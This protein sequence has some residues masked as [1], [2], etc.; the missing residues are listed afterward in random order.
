MILTL[1]HKRTWHNRTPR[2]RRT[3]GLRSYEGGN[4][5]VRACD[6]WEGKGEAQQGLTAFSFFPVCRRQTQT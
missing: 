3:K 4:T 2:R 6:G 5:G 1:I